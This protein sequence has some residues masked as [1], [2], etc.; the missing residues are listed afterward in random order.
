MRSLTSIKRKIIQIY[1][2]IFGSKK[3][4]PKTYSY[5]AVIYH[6]RDM[7]GWTSGAILQKKYPGCTLI[8]YDYGE[9]MP[10]IPRRTEYIIIVDVCMEPMEMRQ[11]ATFGYM[12]LTYI[13]HHTSSIEKFDEDIQQ[14]GTY[15]VGRVFSQPGQKIAACELTWKHCFP[16]DEIPLYVELI[17]SQDSNRETPRYETTARDL[18]IEGF[19]IQ[20]GFI[21]P[22][23]CPEWI[24]TQQIDALSMTYIERQLR[25]TQLYEY[26][27]E[28]AFPAM[29][30]S[31]IAIC[32]ETD[33][34]HPSTF[35]G[36]YDE[37]IHH[38]MVAFKKREKDWVVSI[39]SAKSEINA[40][41]IAKQ[42]GGGG[43]SYAAGFQT[44]DV[45][46][47]LKQDW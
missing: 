24:L 2:S 11:L 40:A 14:H 27:K 46:K 5:I 47:I 3:D 6:S 29:V 31:K 43:H 26:A 28:H 10:Q 20:K 44:K 22:E 9:P 30:A 8:G 15:K 21:S 39:Y 41:D 19:K 45:H 25:T 4:L 12:G 34:F 23:T 1:N 13:D 33:Q 18:L 32:L 16:H 17:G 36:V 35:A 37:K 42:F 7:D 38:I